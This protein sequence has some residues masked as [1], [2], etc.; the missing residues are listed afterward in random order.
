MTITSADAWGIVDSAKN[1]NCEL[2]LSFGWNY[3]R[4][5]Q[6]MYLQLQNKGIGELETMSIQMAP[7]TRK[8]LS[9]TGAYPNAS[10]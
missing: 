2:L 3:Q 4:M 1:N 8:L 5:V 9:N 6:D 7:Q 10:P